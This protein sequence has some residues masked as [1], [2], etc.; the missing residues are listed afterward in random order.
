M[1]TWLAILLIVIALIGGVVIGFFLAKKYMED[2]LQKN[3]PIDEDFI[4]AMMGQ[5]GQKPSESRVR[6]MTSMM[7]KQNA[8]KNKK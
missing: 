8:K 7:K 3:P 5:M 1:N 4:R 2:Y 6:Q